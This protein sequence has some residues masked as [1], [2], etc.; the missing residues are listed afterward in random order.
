[1]PPECRLA[2]RTLGCPAWNADRYASASS[3]KEGRG[4]RAHPT[5]RHRYP[6]FSGDRG[7]S[8]GHEAA[9]R[10]TYMRKD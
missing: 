4:G 3:I 9:I 1:M 5:R 8:S 6:T 10:K 7:A 2:A